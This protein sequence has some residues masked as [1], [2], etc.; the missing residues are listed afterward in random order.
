[1]SFPVT[2][3]QH[4]DTHWAHKKTQTLEHTG[5][6]FIVMKQIDDS[7]IHNDTLHDH[8]IQLQNTLLHFNTPSTLT[9]HMFTFVHHATLPS[10][11]FIDDFGVQK[12][13]NKKEED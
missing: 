5:L 10:P 3:H 7:G 2:T 1:M 4:Q 13:L 9:Q 11:L 12:Q 8:F 6:F